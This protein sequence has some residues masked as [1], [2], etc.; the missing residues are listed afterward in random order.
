MWS[1]RA[2]FPLTLPALVL[3]PFELK[4][5]SVGGEWGA[6][7][8][9]EADRVER[10]E[11]EFCQRHPLQKLGLNWM[12]SEISRRCCFVSQTCS[13]TVTHLFIYGTLI[14]S[15]EINKVVLC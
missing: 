4:M 3:N 1:L 5:V 12:C 15:R 6:G 11:G 13:N 7:G 14:Y 9:G 10:K 2:K 8:R